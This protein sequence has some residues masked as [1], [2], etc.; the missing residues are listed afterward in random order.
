MDCQKQV[1]ILDILLA[2]FLQSKKKKRGVFLNVLS[3]PA[4]E[5]VILFLIY[6]V[7]FSVFLFLT[8]NNNIA[9]RG[10]TVY[11]ILKAKK[12]AAKEKIGYF[13]LQ[14]LFLQYF[15]AIFGKMLTT[16]KKQEQQWQP[17]MDNIIFDVYFFVF[18]ITHCV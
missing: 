16:F 2:F 5:Q 15:N 12:G 4:G 14:L 3:S 7:N 18:K 9:N 10:N 17:K 11:N 8:D 1:K 13:R 6:K